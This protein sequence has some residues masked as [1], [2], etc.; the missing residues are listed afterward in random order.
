MSFFNNFFSKVYGYQ[1]KD[2][3]NVEEFFN[4]SLT[5]TVIILDVR[6]QEEF[7]ESHITKAVLIDYHSSD[8]I[9]KINELDKDK[10]YLVYCRSGNR[11]YHAVQKMLEMGF[12]NPLNLTGGIIEWKKQNKPV[13]NE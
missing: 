13:V 5:D 8:F 1:Q 4:L 7:N 10:T 2:S 6:T 11:S 9:T 3:I 12:K